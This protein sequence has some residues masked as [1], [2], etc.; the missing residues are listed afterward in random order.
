MGAFGLATLRP[1][2]VKVKGDVVEFDFPGK[3]GVR[4]VRHLKDRR[5][6]KVVRSLLR[7]PSRE[8]FRYQNGNGEFVNVTRQHIERLHPAKSWAKSS[9]PKTFAPGPALWFVRVPWRDE[10]AKPEAR[11]ATEAEGCG[12]C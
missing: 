4:Q 11:F 7:R 2:H 3:S 6:A 10:V 9:A 12:G 1:R 8:V 5:V